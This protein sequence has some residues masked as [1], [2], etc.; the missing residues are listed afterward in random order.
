M[1]KKAQLYLIPVPI[2]EEEMICTHTITTLSKL[3][4]INFFVVENAK[5]AR[6]HLKH[7]AIERPLSTLVINEINAE[8]ENRVLEELLKPIEKDNQSIA[9]MS[10]AGCPAIADP[11]AKLVAIAHKKGIEVVPLIGPSSILL[12]L[13]ASGLNGQRFS[14]N[15]YLAIKEIERIQQI[16]SL[17]KR[18]K[19]NNETQICIETPYR[20]QQ[21]FVALINHLQQDTLLTVA[22]DLTAENQFIKTKT[23][24][25]WR[26]DE[27]VLEKKPA[28]YLFL[29]Q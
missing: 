12:A 13:M 15:G 24:R 20:N 14:F 1:E 8:T 19:Q 11:G 21:L 5:V 27:K 25:E 22:L 7:F 6:K 2:T 3:N 26:Q 28:I 10:D 4:H 23:V 17:E 9:L 16:K 18:S 29:S